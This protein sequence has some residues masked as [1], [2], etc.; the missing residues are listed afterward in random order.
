[1]GS[2]AKTHEPS[3]VL[4]MVGIVVTSFSMGWLISGRHPVI[5]GVL[6]VVGLVLT[7]A[8]RVRRTRA[9]RWP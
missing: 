9:G 1:M 7:I 6:F 4:L 8:M 2:P 3:Y 5:A